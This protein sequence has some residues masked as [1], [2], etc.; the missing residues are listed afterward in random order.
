M[1]QGG[2]SVINGPF[3]APRYKQDGDFALLWAE[4]EFADS[5]WRCE[6]LRISQKGNVNEAFLFWVWVGVLEKNDEGS[7]LI[8]LCR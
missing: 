1:S 4:C 5:D 6:R 8:T 2:G 7:H 3:H